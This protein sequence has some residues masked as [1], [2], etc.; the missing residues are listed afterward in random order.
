MVYVSVCTFSQVVTVAVLFVLFMQIKSFADLPVAI[1]ERFWYLQDEC[2]SCE[3][4]K[5]VGHFLLNTPH[6]F[7]VGKLVRIE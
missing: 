6:F 5:S 4:L 3:N 7:T 2:Q 1:D